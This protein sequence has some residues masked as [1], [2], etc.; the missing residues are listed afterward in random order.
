MDGGRDG[1][2]MLA[3]RMHDRR[4]TDALRSSVHRASVAHRRTV[5]VPPPHCRRTSVACPSSVRRA[6]RRPSVIRPK[7]G[8][9]K[10]RQNAFASSARR[11]NVVKSLS[12]SP[13]P[14]CPFRRVVA[15]SSYA[16]RI[17][18]ALSSHRRRIVVASSSRRRCVVVTPSPD[19]CRIVAVPSSQR[20]RVVTFLTV[21][22]PPL[23][24]EPYPTCLQS[25]DEVEAQ[26]SFPTCRLRCRYFSSK[27]PKPS[28]V[29]LSQG[30][31]VE[32]AEETVIKAFTELL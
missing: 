1:Q 18:V 24:L 29:E 8:R 2:T 5:V 30:T 25:L 20:R 7:L 3:R 32:T 12:S 22:T 11:R 16:R 31:F 13:L 26:E 17:V 28:T 27:S 9:N 21:K 4:A 14:S 23:I 19:R 15:S 6:W 10:R